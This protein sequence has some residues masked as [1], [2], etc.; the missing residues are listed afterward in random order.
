MLMQLIR[1]LV[2]MMYFNS[3]ANL[4]NKID[5]SCYKILQNLFTNQME[6]ISCQ[7]MLL[8]SQLLTTQE[9]GTHTH[10]THTYTQHIHT[11]VCLFVCVCMYTQSHQVYRLATYW[12]LLVQWWLNIFS[13]CM[14]NY[15]VI[16][17]VAKKSYCVV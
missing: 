9:V 13:Y 6:F 2:L 3:K 17:T 15:T 16:F 14:Y 11:C 1:R 12:C 5:Y 10:N 8:T 4:T 7:I